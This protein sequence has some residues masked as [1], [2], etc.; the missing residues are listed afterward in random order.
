MKIDFRGT[1]VHDPELK[2]DYGAP[3]SSTRA[4][5]LL[6]DTGCSSF[7]VL[8]VRVP[9]QVQLVAGQWQLL[10]GPSLQCPTCGAR[11]WYRC[12]RKGWWMKTVVDYCECSAFCGYEYAMKYYDW[13]GWGYVGLLCVDIMNRRLSKKRMML[14]RTIG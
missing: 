3:R 8:P 14:R 9:A 1:A 13:D 5:E 10:R 7:G 4:E 6:A 2:Y 11:V 12:F